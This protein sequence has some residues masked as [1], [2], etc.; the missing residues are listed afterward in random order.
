[1]DSFFLYSRGVRTLFSF[2]S[3]LKDYGPVFFANYEKFDHLLNSL[4]LFRLTL[5]Y[6]QYKVRFA[7]YH[8][9]I[10]FVFL[11]YSC[12]S[13]CEH[14]RTLLPQSTGILNLIINFVMFFPAN[15]W[16]ANATIICCL[17]IVSC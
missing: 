7:A 10:N 5:G 9:F 6:L 3:G 15:K 14:S 2:Q 16:V 12:P 8:A 11:T 13:T 17:L 4:S 1:V